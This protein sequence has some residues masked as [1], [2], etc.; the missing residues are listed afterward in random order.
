M[1]YLSC[2]HTRIYPLPTEPCEPPGW[3]RPIREGAT[4][5]WVVPQGPGAECLVA[6]ADVVAEHHLFVCAPYKCTMH[7]FVVLLLCA[8][9]Y[10]HAYTY[11][12][13][14]KNMYITNSMHVPASMLAHNYTK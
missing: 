3:R 11:I 2:K 14:N 1:L 9:M 7:N 13:I 10:V 6:K 4:P 12:Y 5:K 8:F